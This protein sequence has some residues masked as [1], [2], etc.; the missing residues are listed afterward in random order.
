L[1]TTYPQ[2][3]A[4]N[5][6]H[7]A[8]PSSAIL[9]AVIFNAL[10]IVALIPLALKGVQYRAVGAAALLRRNLLIYGVGG[11]I[12]PFIGIKAID[13]VLSAFNLVIPRSRH[14]K[15]SSHIRPAL[16]MFTVLTLACGVIYPLAVTG[17]A[18][19]LFPSQAAGSLIVRERQA[20]RLVADRPELQRPRY[21]WGR[22]SATG[23]M[24]NNAAAS[25]G[26]NQGPLNPALDGRRQGPHRSA[27]SG[28]PR[29][30]RGRAG[31]PGHGL[32]QRPRSRTSA[33]RR[34]ATRPAAWPRRA[35]RHAGRCW[36]WSNSTAKPLWP[37]W[38]T[39]ASLARRSVNVLELNLALDLGPAR[40]PRISSK[41]GACPF[42][43]R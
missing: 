35:D 24:P 11:L 21:F 13:L 34:R 38:A 9:S 43:H 10:I 28:R 15:P 31:R 6:M 30:H 26:A 5:M 23:P 17:A 16:V 3:A 8:S 41:I 37:S 7:L 12:V 4:L 25:S 33:W 40:A 32:G 2:L 42:P 19:S 36:R 18:Q 22:P 29:Q 14:V 39:W 27:Q 1:S 20:G